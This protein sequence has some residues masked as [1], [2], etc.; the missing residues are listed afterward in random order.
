M[1]MT[2]NLVVGVVLFSS[3]VAGAFIVTNVATHVFSGAEEAQITEEEAKTIAEEH[4][5]GTAISVT[6]EKEDDFL[7]LEFGQLIY[8]VIVETET[9]KYE[10]EIDAETGNVLE[11]EPDDGD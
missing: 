5:D 6:L 2:I 4:T 8:E 3:L 7:E 10:V 11:V 9:G 1:S